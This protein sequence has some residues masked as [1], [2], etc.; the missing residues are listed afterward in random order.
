MINQKIK[1]Q[2]KAV[3][4]SIDHTWIVSAQSPTQINLLNEE[5]KYLKSEEAIEPL[6]VRGAYQ[7][8]LRD[9][10][11]SY[12]I[13]TSTYRK[14]H[15]PEQDLDGNYNYIIYLICVYEYV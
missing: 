5:L 13:L 6:I 3:E 8:R 11:V 12:F 1:F 10:V 14:K 2:T 4:A 7:V 15:I 9:C